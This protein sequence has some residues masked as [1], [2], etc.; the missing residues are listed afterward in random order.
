MISTTIQKILRIFGLQISRI[1]EKRSKTNFKWLTNMQVATVIDI[2]ANIGQS[3]NIYRQLCPDA[4]IY[5]FEPLGDCYKQLVSKFKK[6]SRVQAFNVALSNQSGQAMFNRNQF[7]AA[8]SFLEITEY[9]QANYPLSAGKIVQE[10]IRT[11]RLDDFSKNLN[12]KEP[13]LIKVDVQGSEAKVIEGGEEVFKKASVVI[14]EMSL[15]YLYR[16][17]PL[18][19]DIYQKLKNLGFSYSG[20]SD[21]SHSIHDGRVIF[22]D[23]IFVK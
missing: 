13:I 5:S 18:F 9:T 15:E 8:S 12:L 2:G 22:V 4:R 6:D 14:I 21:Q 17:Q 1:P 11:E 3:I 10:E 19:D 16:G 23:A 20:N 7:S